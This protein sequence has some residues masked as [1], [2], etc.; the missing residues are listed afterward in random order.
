VKEEQMITGSMTIRAP[1]QVDYA[2]SRSP[3]SHLDQ[4][5][6]AG[7][8]RRLQ[9]VL[10]IEDDRELADALAVRLQG[11]GLTVARAQDG[12]SGLEKVRLLHP[13][14]IILDLRLPR[15]EGDRFLHFL[16][17]TAEHSAVPV[18]VITG[19]SDAALLERVENWGV[20]R[21]MRKPVS[22]KE[23]LRAALDILHAS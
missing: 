4:D 15:M 12:A 21:L 3:Q 11:T 8:P 14:L 13:D 7:E 6:G 17:M 19:T 9:V 5:I 16:R 20:S 10:L 2:A 22:P 23:L 18:I 1:E